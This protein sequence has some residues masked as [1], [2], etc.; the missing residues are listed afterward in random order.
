MP[1][2]STV[3]CGSCGGEL[4]ATAR[5]C[6]SCGA[7]Q[8]PAALP[9]EK[10]RTPAPTPRAAPTPTASFQSTAAPV[11]TRSPAR[12]T[13]AFLAIADG[14]GVC[15]MVLYTLV[16]LPLHYHTSILFGEGPQVGDV[17]AFSC[18]VLAISLGVAALRRSASSYRGTG[19]AIAAVGLP[20]LVL[21]LVWTFAET[22]GLDYNFGRPFY[23]GYVYFARLGIIHFGGSYESSYVQVPLLASSVAVLLGGILIAG[24]REP[25]AETFGRR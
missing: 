12:A 7:S 1:G 19:V 14:I 3:F 24:A 4:T 2:E 20:V 9:P 22:L 8:G 5:F 6:R 11:G 15:F 25:H 16:Y 17:L 23:F 18:G 10:P 13:G 21:C